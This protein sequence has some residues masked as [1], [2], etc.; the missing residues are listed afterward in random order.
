[1]KH[2]IILLLTYVAAVGQTSLR[3][4][5]TIGAATPDFLWLVL[6]AIV[7]SIDGWP[8]IVWAALVGL[9]A[10]CIAGGRLGS[11][12]L[13]VLLV[14]GVAQTL[15]QTRSSRSAL[16]VPLWLCFIVFATGLLSWLAQVLLA[17]QL[18]NNWTA[19]LQVLL[20]ATYTSLLGLA[21]I[22]CWCLVKSRLFRSETINVRSAGYRRL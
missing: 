16:M 3:S 7:L 15:Q 19:V 12:M 8:A 10:D 22:V 14:V 18:V 13:A 4:E 6:V 9:L 17:E 1:M 2:I 20:S 11:G 5:L 21:S